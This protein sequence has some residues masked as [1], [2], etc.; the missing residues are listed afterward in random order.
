MGEWLRHSDFFRLYFMIRSKYKLPHL[1]K[2]ILHIQH[3]FVICPLMLLFPKP[4]DIFNAIDKSSILGYYESVVFFLPW[5]FGTQTFL[6]DSITFF[7]INIFVKHN[8]FLNGITKH[9][10]I[11]KCYTEKRLIVIII[12]IFYV[13]TI[14]INISLVRII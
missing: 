13:L 2:W 3:I 6:M 14:K 11:L 10:I 8:V 5:I 4:T 9:F 7:I 12:K 1:F